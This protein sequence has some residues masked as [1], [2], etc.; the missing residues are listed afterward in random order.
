MGNTTLKIFMATEFYWRGPRGAYLLSPNMASVVRDVFARMQA[1]LS[2]KRF[3]DWVFVLGTVV[4]VR[5]NPSSGGHPSQRGKTSY[6][7]FAPIQIGGE[8]RM[9]VEFKHHISAIDFPETPQFSWW[10][11]P[12]AVP[13]PNR[14]ECYINRGTQGCLYRA[15]P[16]EFL[17]SA[18]GFESAASLQDGV[19]EVK[20]LKLGIEICLDHGQ[21]R[22]ARE[23]GPR[24]TVDVHLIVSA[25]MF[26]AAG[27]VGTKQGGPVLLADG[28]G[29]TAMSQNIY[30]RGREA[31]VKPDGESHYN[32]GVVYGADT[33]V[34]LGQWIGQSIEAFTGTRWRESRVP[35]FGTLPGGTNDELTGIAFAQVPALGDAWLQKLDGLFVTSNYKEAEHVYSLIKADIQQ[36]Q[37]LNL[38]NNITDFALFSPTIDMYGPVPIV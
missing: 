29:R 28:F 8:H 15:L 13:V 24:R 25:G 35:G 38:Y 23:L 22:L 32:V 16:S 3:S 37:D 4:A 1:R 10:P 14:T 7:N 30:G 20:G 36:R 26:I 11:A 17:E 18:F 27:P 2:D 31:A 34:A 5:F 9:H 6:F 12:A 33:M 19:F 21:G